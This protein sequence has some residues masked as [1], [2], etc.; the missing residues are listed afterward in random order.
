MKLLFLFPG[1]T[2]PPSDDRLNRI[3]F[4]SHSNS[5]DILLPVWFS[6]AE[7]AK[8]KLGDDSFPHKFVGTFRY[9]FLCLYRYPRVLRTL[10]CFAFFL[11]VGYRLCRR[12]HYD[13]IVAYGTSVTGL[14]GALLSHLVDAPLIAE[15]PGVPDKAFIV[16]TPSPS[17]GTR[18]KKFVADRILD[19]VAHTSAGLV[20]LFPSQ[21]P[22]RLNACRAQRFV[23]HAFVPVSAVPCSDE[24]P[25]I[26]LVGFPW[27]LKGV[28]LICRAFNLVKAEIPDYRLVLMGHY[29][30]I[31]PFLDSLESHD[32]IVL[33]KP[34]PYKECLSEIASCAFLVLPSRTEAMGRVILEAMAAGRPVIGSRVDGIPFYIDDHKTGLLVDP[35]DVDQ[36]AT[37][38][39]RLA[40][41][42]SLRETLGAAAREK[43]LSRY[44]ESSYATDFDTMLRCVLRE[45]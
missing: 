42:R 3:H 6:S 14:A 43:V 45:R 20:L 18:I 32:R 38:V 12:H 34:T 31:P 35:E 13:A 15:I 25:T 16:D 40:S 11:V 29:P 9:T 36:L 1:P 41:D 21:L 7:M 5:G 39:R 26:L 23:L 24:T 30:D 2:P 19:F 27:Y 8:A 17:I 10:A 33:K 37:A 22:K 44:L 4:I 28:D